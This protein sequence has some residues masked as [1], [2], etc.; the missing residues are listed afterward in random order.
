MIIK[1]PGLAVLAVLA[2]AV[3]LSGCCC[4]DGI[5]GYGGCKACGEFSDIAWQGGCGGGGTCCGDC[6]GTCGGCCEGS[7][8]CGWG[9]DYPAIAAGWYPCHGPILGLFASLRDAF[10]SGG[11]GGC[12]CQYY[13]E[14]ASDP[15]LCRDPCPGAYGDCSC[16]ESCG[17][18]CGA[19]CAGNCGGS[20][21]SGQMEWSPG[22]AMM[23]GG[24]TSPPHGGDCNCGGG[25]VRHAPRR[26]YP[27]TTQRRR[28]PTGPVPR[29]AQR[30]AQ[31]A[32]RGSAV[33]PVTYDN[34]P[35]RRSPGVSG[36]R[37]SS[38]PVQAPR[39]IQALETEWEGNSEGWDY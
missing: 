38:L 13:D 25:Q 34:A 21:G 20:Y 3:L 4:M 16:G 31:Q 5:C 7:P 35:G 15:P 18:S 32:A 1:H 23:E 12:G 11:C 9:P 2:M 29:T 24:Y 8:A 6:G 37:P 39:R 14:W 22:P 28:S 27:Q 36:A 33:R 19:S 10:A 17:G 30:T 26:G